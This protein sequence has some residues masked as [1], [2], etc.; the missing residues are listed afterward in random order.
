M[1]LIDIEKSQLEDLVNMRLRNDLVPYRRFVYI[2]EMSLSSASRESYSRNGVSL[3][4]Q[5]Y[6]SYGAS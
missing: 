1:D 3:S 2:G 5:S 4:C 6:Q